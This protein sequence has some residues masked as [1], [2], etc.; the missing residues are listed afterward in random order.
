VSD[1]YLNQ[2]Q[3]TALWQRF[4]KVPYAPRV[5]VRRAD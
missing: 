4:L 3:W 1:G 5:D 2:E